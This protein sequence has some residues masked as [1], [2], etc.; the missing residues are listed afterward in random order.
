MWNRERAAWIAVLACALACAG[1]GG[2][3]AEPAPGE[4]PPASK[5][6]RNPFGLA[7]IPDCCGPTVHEFAREAPGLAAADDENASAWVH[8]GRG[9]H[10]SI[11]GEWAGRWRVEEGEWIS[12]SATIRTVGG[13]VYIHHRD[14]AEYL[15]EAER[16]GDRL[17]G[18]YVN[19]RDDRDT[20]PWVGTVV[21]NERIDGSWRS[22][23]WDFRRGGAGEP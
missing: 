23:R 8:M 6:A 20:S 16:E 3:R 1:C 21:S 11:D 18:R 17:V 15:I 22:G 14:T 5:A 12:G 9:P 13:R 19:T 4:A 7:D 10:T 2:E